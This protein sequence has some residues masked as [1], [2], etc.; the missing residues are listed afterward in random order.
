M[1]PKAKFD[2]AAPENAELIARFERFGLTTNSATEL[3]RTPKSG[4]AFRA[5]VDETGLEGK[6]FPTSQANALVKLSATGSKLSPD[7]RKY[8]VQRIEDGSVVSPDQVA[9]EFGAGVF[10]ARA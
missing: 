8:I 10:Q 4:T 9:G 2:P 1:A 6:A 5:L 3:V 7:A